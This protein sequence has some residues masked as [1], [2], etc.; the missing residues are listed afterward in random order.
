[1]YVCML[2]IYDNNNNMNERVE[3]RVNNYNYNYNLIY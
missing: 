2:D 3:R 1:M